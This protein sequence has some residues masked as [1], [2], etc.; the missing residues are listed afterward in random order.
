MKISLI[1]C[2]DLPPMRY[3]LLQHQLIIID[4]Y[5][6]FYVL[7]ESFEIIVSRKQKVVT[8][9]NSIFTFKQLKYYFFKTKVSAFYDQPARA[10][11]SLTPSLV[12][13]FSN[14]QKS[15][16]H[17]ATVQLH[18]NSSIFDVNMSQLHFQSNAKSFQPS[19]KP[20]KSSINRC[21][22]NIISIH[23]SLLELSVIF[24]K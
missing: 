17:H 11:V 6:L 15:I 3:T 10:R 24:K 5:Y 13:C 21:V 12:W 9:K 16:Y 19:P 20:R 23:S 4:Y 18:F 2:N 14:T 8:T 7:D 22:C 1:F